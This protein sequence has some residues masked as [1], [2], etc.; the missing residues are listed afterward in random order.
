MASAAP[1]VISV[2]P[3]SSANTGPRE[4]DLTGTGFVSGASVLLQRDGQ[5]DIVGTSVTVGALGAEI[6]A[7]FNLTAAAPGAWDVRVTNPDTSTDVCSACFTVTAQAPTV[8]STSPSSRGQG[9]TSQNIAITGTNFAQGAQASFSGTGITVNSTIFL[10]TTQVT[11]NITLSPTASVGARNVTVTNTDAQSGSC[12]GC[13]TVNA[14]PVVTSVAPAQLPNTAP[15]QLTFTGTGFVSGISV[16]LELAGQ[17]AIPGTAVEVVDATTMTATF[18]LTD[19]APEDWDVHVTNADAGTSVC[20]GCFTITASDP[21]VTSASPASRGQGATDQDIAING[22]DFAMGASVSFSGTGITVN[23]TTFVDSTELTANITIAGDATTGLRDITVT[24]T[25]GKTGS[26]T[27]CFTVNAGPTV[28]GANPSSRG[29]GATSQSITITGTGFVNG[30]AVTFSG[31]GI[32][33][34]S[35]TFVGAT[36]LTANIT[37]SGTAATGARDITVTNPDAGIGTCAG[38]FTV[39]TGPTVTGTNPSSLGQ[40]ATTED[41]TVTGTGFVDGAAVTFSGTG[42]TVN[43]TT[44]VGATTL[45]ANITIS[46]AAATGLRDV[47][48]TNPDGGKKTCVACFTVNAAPTVTDVTPDN[49]GQGAADQDL[50]VTGTGFQDGATVSFSG[51]GIDVDEVTF[52]NATTLTVNVNVSG[53][54]TPGA[55]DVTITNPDAGTPAVCEDCFTVNAAPTATSV[56]PN[57]LG[58]GATDV[59]LTVTG[60]GFQDGATVAFSGTGITVNDVTFVGPTTLTV[61]V[62]VSSTATTGA[63]TVTVTNPDEGTPATCVACFTVNTG[64]TVTDVSPSAATNTEP[65]ELTLTGT[66]FASGAT[67]HLERTGQSDIVGTSVVVTDPT[68]ASAEFEITAAAPGDWDVV[69]INADVGTA[70]CVA[71][72]TIAGSAPSVSD[73]S[74]ASRGQG[75]VDEDVTITGLNFAMGAV[76]SFSGTGITINDTTFVDSTELTVNITIS[77]TAPTGARNVTV[78]NTDAQSG[79]CTGCFTVTA[80]PNVTDV[81]PDSLALGAT[82]ADVSVIG[83]GFQSTTTVGFSGTGI[84]VNGTTFVNATKIVVNV[85][86]APD[87]PVGAR[88]VT[89]T[90]LDGGTPAVCTGCFTVREPMTAMTPGVVRGNVWYLADEAPPGAVTSFAFGRPTDTPIVGDWDGDGDHEPGVVRGN[91]WYLADEAPPVVVSSFAFGRATDIPIVG[92]WDGAG[93]D[94]IGVVRGNVWYLAEDVPPVVVSSFAFGRATDTPIVGNWDGAG[95]DEIGVVRG[96]VWYLAN[97]VPP[98][99]SFSFAFGR[100]TDT[101]ITGDFDGDGDDEIGVVRENVWYLADEA[102]PTAAFSFAF[103]RATDIQI[104]GDWD[105]P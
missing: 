71:C 33:V 87:A 58:Q 57:D 98:T 9:A 86:L 1:D 61:N 2:S 32:T 74:P 20:A 10:N 77:G 69:F 99:S 67:I 66:G 91:V 73:V 28:S 36:T 103:G 22:S 47:T 6:L 42:I 52:V 95:G 26:C 19:V 79:T 39:N 14:S 56:S 23:S 55:R 51:T 8:G 104:V 40:G 60:T 45:T 34:N 85:T 49:L 11:A 62:T 27:G 35:T 43:S 37:I 97:D 29:Q 75:A 76:V 50:T 68:E 89:V 21:E 41:I 83:T 72:F 30:A 63:R 93:G 64:P 81:V 15:A 3:S 4:L 100:P 7:T 54:A 25:D 17:P 94:E 13:F 48:V 78:T 44:F 59:D 38:C 105:G 102:P 92:N 90:N 18:D 12:T 88:N 46:G 82:E 101:P 16:Q 70:T 84:T 80:K 31:T 53:T 24:N 65:V 96:N 5:S